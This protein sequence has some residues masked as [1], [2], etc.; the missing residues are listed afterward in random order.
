MPPPHSEDPV[1]LAC[2]P[3]PQRL[4]HMTRTEMLVGE[5]VMKRL[6]HGAFAM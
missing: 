2:D 3:D 4:L 5:D 6:P 1:A